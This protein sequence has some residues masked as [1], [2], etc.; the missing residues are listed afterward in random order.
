MLHQKATFISLIGFLFTVCIPDIFAGIYFVDASGS[1]ACSDN[2]SNGMEAKPWCSI[3]Y[4]IGRI[5]GGDTLYVKAGTYREDIYIANPAGTASYDTIIKAY[6]GHTVLLNGGGVNTGRIKIANTNH[7]TFDGFIITNYNQGLFIENADNIT[8]QNCIIYN[9]GQEGLHIRLNSS[10]ITVQNCLIHDTRAWQYNGEG[11][12]IGTAATS[13]P[14]DNTHHIAIRNNTIYNTND[15]CI[16]IK[17]GTHDCVIEGNAMSHCLTD[18]AITQGSWG[19]IEIDEAVNGNQHWDSNPGHIVRNNVIHD[20]KTALRTGTGSTVYNNVIY[21]IAAPYNGIYINNDANDTYSRRIYYNTIDLPNARA[22]VVAGGIADV[23]NN[24]GPTT[25]GNMATSANYY[26][27]KV[28]A[29]YHLVAG[30]APIDA[31]VDL[32]ATVPT[33]LEGKPRTVPTD[34]GAY[35][36]RIVLSTPQ[37]LRVLP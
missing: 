15:E 35:E 23:K 1:P 8:I 3:N 37:N 27:N 6:P 24:I 12:Y 13:T 18:P 5:A 2:V 9:V 10:Y 21:N 17:P 32:N 16:E 33:D 4:G 28:D 22:I 36:Y 34:S 26:V 11:I 20:T 7:I 25:T 19:S 14:L 29:D 31:G 30:S